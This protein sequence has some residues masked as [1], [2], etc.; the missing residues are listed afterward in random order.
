MSEVINATVYQTI[1]ETIFIGL[2]VGLWAVF[3]VALFIRSLWV[4][5]P[6]ESFASAGLIICFAWPFLLFVAPFMGAHYCL[7]KWVQ[8]CRAQEEE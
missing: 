8:H 6:D 5:E 1:F 3:F 2:Y 7:R 4:R